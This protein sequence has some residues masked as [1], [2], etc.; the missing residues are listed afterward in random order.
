MGSSGDLDSEL[1]ENPN[2][3]RRMKGMAERLAMMKN[4]EARVGDE[5]DHWDPRPGLISEV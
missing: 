2:F 5:S 3:K 4:K 1:E